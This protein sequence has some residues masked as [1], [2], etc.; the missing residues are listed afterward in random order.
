MYNAAEQSV[1]GFTTDVGEKTITVALAEGSKA[2]AKGTNVGEYPMGL[3]EDDFTV[4]SQNYS[5]IKVVVVDGK[6]T[7]TSSDDTF[8]ISLEDDTYTYDGNPHSNTKTASSTAASGTTSFSY[9][10]TEDG[11]Y[12]ADLNSLTKVDAG[13]YTIYVIGTNPNYN[14]SASTTAKLTINKKAATITTGSD[15]KQYDGT[16]LTKDEASI[17]GL[18]EGETA[19]VTATGSQ[20]E[21]GK[22]NN[23]Y[24]ISWGTAKASNYNITDNLGTLTVTSSTDEVKLTAGSGSKTYDG[25]AL[26][27]ATVTASGLPEGFSVEATATGSQTD[28]GESANVVDDGY[29]IK[30]ASGND[31]TDNFKNVTKVDGKLT[32]NPASVTIKTGSDTKAYD[33]AALTNAEASISGLVNNETA[34]VTATGSQTEVGSS[35]NTYS[36][37]WGTAKASNYTIT[38]ELGTL[39]VT[40]NG[41][42]EV[43]LTAASDSKTYDGK[44][45]TNATV[46]ASGLPEGFTVEASASGSQTNV[47]ESANVVDDGYVIKDANGND[48]TSNFTNV[49]KVDGTLTV[50]PAQVTIKT[51]S[52]SKAYDGAALTN[53]EASITGL[54]NNETATVTATGSQTEVGS[55]NNTYSIDWGTAKA[56]NYTIKE[57]LGTLEVTTNGTVEVKLTAASDSKT[58]DGKALTN[59]TVTASG[60]PEGFTVEASASG[61]QTNVGESAN[62]V[63]DGYVIKDANGNDKT[64]NFTNVTKVDGTL[65]VKPAQVTIKT[66][67]GSKAYD[68]AALTNSE[69]SI[70]GLVNNETATVT[71]TGSQTEVG[72]SNNTYSIDWGTTNK[73]NYEVTEE[74]GTLEVTTNSSEVKL[75]AASGSKTYDGTALSNATVTASGLPEGFSVE[76][77]ASGSQTDAGES[78][79]VVDSYVIKNAKGED[80]TANFTNIKLVDGKLTVNPAPVTLTANSGS[81]T[82]NGSEQSIDGFESSVDGLT[83]EGVTAS[84]SGTDA[85]TYDVTF[86]GV[87][88]DETTDSTGN[89]V[90]TAT[91]NGTFT[92]DRADIEGDDFIVSQP[93]D[94]MYDGEEHK[95]PVTVTSTRR[96][97]LAEGTDYTL[98]YSGDLVN[99]GTV[100]VTVEG[101]GNYKGTVLRYYDITPRKV[102]LTSE[103]AKKRYDG[104]PLTRPEV[105]VSGDGFV[106]GEVSDITAIGTITKPGTVTNTITF[107]EGENF[108][109][110]NYDIVKIEGKLTVYKESSG[111]DKTPELNKEDHIA[112][113]IGYEDDTV[114]PENNITRAEVAMI[115]FRLLTEDTRNAALTDVN[116]YSDVEVGDWYNTAVSTMSALGI[117]K[118]YPDGTFKPNNFI[119]RAEFAAIAARFDDHVSTGAVSFT[120]IAGHWAEEEVSRAAELGWVTGYPDGTFRPDRYITRAEAMTLINRVLI[121]NPETVEDLLEEM[122]IWKDN[123]DPDCWYY[124]AVQEASISHYYDR[125]TNGTEFWTGLRPDVW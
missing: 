59:A 45:L 48:K 96:A 113:V 36:I 91:N 97:I 16:P 19:T 14:S 15:L 69:A 21:V 118:G 29:V 73:D 66:G 116:S 49:T 43:K 11:D 112:Y 8:E 120:D 22:S 34:T 31:K 107:T 18:V 10:F 26:T 41:T 23:T 57:E 104:T 88:L 89:Y 86:T 30:D 75:T 47:G 64:S 4:T 95:Q 106:D 67:S 54:V 58:Y 56:S 24:S 72:S 123:A 101:I 111:G 7:I 114:R 124:I 42:V 60:L 28:V 40:T 117:I 53:S 17:E 44:A 115:F 93:E 119:T 90:I 27:N 63:D 94:V 71:A 50:K 122:P 3:T 79:N 38:E 52:G 87:T 78:A 125:K 92:I 108:N 103:S 46:T 102:T 6:L 74:L 82:Y 33:G 62:V 5:N 20:T 65:T 110:S 9:S 99:V 77:S 85:G 13:D 37:E 68:G 35:N 98:T 51:G 84:G 109:A 55:S 76:A 70:T 83:F 39:E 105:M 121:R 61:S 25:T 32:V 1:T 81:A 2:E 12:V 100:T 80:K